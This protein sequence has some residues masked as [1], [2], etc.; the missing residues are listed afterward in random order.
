[1]GAEPKKNNKT[2]HKRGIENSIDIIKE[3]LTEARMHS[4]KQQII[5]VRTTTKIG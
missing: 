2:K 1:M 4:I 3:N 5:C